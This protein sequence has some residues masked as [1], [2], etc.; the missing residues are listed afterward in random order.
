MKIS[1]ITVGPCLVQSISETVEKRSDGVAV[2][3]VKCVWMG[4]EKRWK[5]PINLVEGMK[6][7]DQIQLSFEAVQLIEV[8]QSIQSSDGTINYDDIHVKLAVVS[9]VKVGR[10]KDAS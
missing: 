6:Q 1:P 8:P 2:Q 3:A 4:G 7:G 9:D 10:V 5:I